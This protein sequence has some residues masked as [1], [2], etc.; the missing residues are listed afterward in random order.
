MRTREK[1]LKWTR[2]AVLA[3]LA[4]MTAW[5]VRAGEAHVVPDVVGAVSYSGY[6]AVRSMGLST[7]LGAELAPFTDP[8][9]E[10]EDRLL[11]WQTAGIAFRGD[12]QAD[13]LAVVIEVLDQFAGTFGEAAFLRLVRQALDGDPANRNP[14]LTIAKTADLDFGAAFWIPSQATV[15][16]TSD[17]FDQAY[18]EKHYSWSVFDRP[19]SVAPRPITLQAAVIAHELGHVLIDGIRVTQVGTGEPVPPP[20]EAYAAQ[21]DVNFWP[22]P[23]HPENENLATEL[24]LWALELGRSQ[25]VVAFREHY[26]AP[27]LTEA[28]FKGLRG[29]CKAD[30]VF[31]TKV[32]TQLLAPQVQ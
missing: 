27:Y 23:H 15:Y 25:P 20:E 17:L 18:A 16:F 11:H 4:F 3:A 10:Q 22:H 14:R 31:Y 29:R 13:E 6:P 8:C 24:G 28:R 30:G 26:L 32:Q 5:G 2:L 19:S 7:L 12:W 1:W 21:L 9:G